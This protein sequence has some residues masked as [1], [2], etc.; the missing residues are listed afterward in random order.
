MNLSVYI[1]T[2]IQY[3]LYKPYTLHFMKEISCITLYDIHVTVPLLY[4]LHHGT[5]NF[6][7]NRL[8]KSSA[9]GKESEQVATSL[10]QTFLRCLRMTLLSRR[11]LIQTTKATVVNSGCTGPL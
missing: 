5:A 1:A 3:V 7:K 2:V 4:S 11:G 6:R 10:S 8:R 9:D